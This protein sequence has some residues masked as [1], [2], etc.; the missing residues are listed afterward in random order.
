[1]SRLATSFHSLSSLVRS[2]TP[3]SDE[4]IRRAVPSI[5]AERPHDSCSARY[6]YIPTSRV[7]DGL[8]HEGFQP[9]FACQT[10]VRLPDRADFTKHLIRLR[11][12]SRITGAQANEIILVNSHDGSSAYQML[13]GVFRFV[14]HNGLICGDQVEDLRVRH[15][16]N[17]VDRVIEGAYTILD[18]FDRIDAAREGMFALPLDAGE[19]RA[20]ARAALALR[21]EGEPPIT[22]DQVLDPHRREDTGADLWSTFNRAQ[23]NLVRGGLRTRTANGRRTRTR[24]VQGIDQ[25]V[26]LNRAL[27]TLA[28]E[29]RKL[30]TG[31]DSALAHV[32]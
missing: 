8:R 15:S 31:E 12:A 13:A 2:D 1:M 10:R 16:G 19:Q 6:G 30:K 17:V 32:A 18:E 7:L 28:D 26:K 23:E 21:F 27:W 4:Q 5:Y 14:C 20:F 11:P 22:P 29:L 25:G 9:F 3:L 24:P